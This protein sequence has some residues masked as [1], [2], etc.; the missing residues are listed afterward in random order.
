MSRLKIAT[1]GVRKH[2]PDLITAN[3]V[4][5]HYRQELD[6]HQRTHYRF[7]ATSE[8]TATKGFPNA[9]SS[10]LC[11]NFC[12]HL[13][14]ASRQRQIV[15]ASCHQRAKT[16]PP[17]GSMSPKASLLP[18]SSLPPKGFQLLPAHIPR[19]D[20]CSR[21]SSASRQRQIILA[22]NCIKRTS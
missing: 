14:S 20:F 7:T 15:L 8:R 11:L 21:M 18:M 22:S 9:T 19:R 4:L 12:S 10:R 2:Y 16:L 1:T 17:K 13:S 6:C 3:K 5:K